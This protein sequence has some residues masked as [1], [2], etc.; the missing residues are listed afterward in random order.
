M[1][2]GPNILTV[3]RHMEHQMDLSVPPIAEAHS[4]PPLEAGVSV[5]ELQLTSQPAEPSNLQHN[6]VL[7]TENSLRD[8]GQK[9]DQP[10]VL[11]HNSIETVSPSNSPPLEDPNMI[12]HLTPTDSN[13]MSQD[14]PPSS[15]AQLMA[16]ESALDLATETA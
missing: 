2:M 12:Q 3:V 5:A 13:L 9:L 8:V 7:I 4:L 14:D 1:V 15:L 6:S 11:P 10:E 16:A